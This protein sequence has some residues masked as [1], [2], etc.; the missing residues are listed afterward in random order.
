MTGSS[1]ADLHL[2]W[3]KSHAG[4]I[5]HS[6]IG[7]LMDSAATAE[8]IW[9]H[10]IPVA[11]RNAVDSACERRGREVFVATC[12]LHDIGKATP[13]FQ[14]KVPL[15]AQQV[16]D[17]GLDWGL[18]TLADAHLWHHTLA[19]AAII[20]GLTYRSGTTEIHT[21]VSSLVS[22]HHG[23]L[24][25][26]VGRPRKSHGGA[27]WVA[28]QEELAV[29]VLHR[30][31]SDLT[32]LNLPA[33]SP[34]TQ[35]SL[36]GYVTMADW[37]ASSD[38]FPGLGLRDV[39]LAEARARADR[40]WIHLGIRSG[41]D[42]SA[43]S[44]T[45]FDE[46]FGRVPAPLQD[47][48]PG[49]I[50]T[51]DGPALLIVE[52]PMGEGKTEAAL[53]ATEHLSA[54]LGF[55]GFVFAMPTQGT[56]DA[57]YSRVTKWAESV[58]REFTVSLLHG[59]AMLNQE[60]V[61]RLN[62]QHGEDL[63]DIYDEDDPF[64][65]GMSRAD[66]A[67]VPA[68]WLLGRHRSL[69][70]PGVVG[71]VDQI[72]WA[73]TRTRFVSLRHAGLAGKVVIIDEVHSFDVHMSQFVHELL[74]WCGDGGIPVLLMSATLPA[75]TRDGLVA[76]Y[77]GRD[78]DSLPQSGD[79]PRVTVAGPER[80]TTTVACASRLRPASVDVEV[81]DPADPDDL[82]PIA[83][84][85]ADEVADGG[86]ALVIL[87]T[88]ARAQGV[89]RL[90][91]DRSVD[92]EL[93]HGRLTTAE[94]ARRTHAAVAALGPNVAR[95]AQRVIVATQI[96]EQS[97]DVDADVLFSDIAPIDLLLQRMGRLHRHARSAEERPP[98]LRRPRT[99]ITGVRLGEDP[100]RWISAFD[101]V[102]GQRPE[103]KGR[104]T[105]SHAL[106]ATC[107]LLLRHPSTWTMP[108]DI[109]DLV[110]YGY[111]D[112]WRESC[113]WPEAAEQ[114][115]KDL[116][117]D[118]TRR[119]SRAAT[120]TLGGLQADLWRTRDI[121][122]L[123]ALPVDDE[124][125]VVRDGEPTLEVCLVRRSADGYF[126]LD[127]TPLG[128]TGSRATDPD[129]ARRLLGDTVRVRQD[130]RL[131]DLSAPSGFNGSHLL[132]RQPTLV[133]DGSFQATTPAGRVSYDLEVGLSIERQREG[134]PH[135]P[136]V[137]GTTLRPLTGPDDHRE[138]ATRRLY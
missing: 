106:L 97:F 12:G 62:S 85:V 107:D 53:W 2:L 88:V 129:V 27:R 84:R 45:T 119:R 79:Y 108:T 20:D 55:E 1:S 51:L 8:L 69:L 13:A 86:V 14:S 28:V 123:H 24:K 57:M 104:F 98:R 50:K 16:R 7:H 75:A 76:A 111:S 64:G 72:L 92:V 110:S 130:I 133:L 114:A 46:R 22:G 91:R 136:A 122:D 65:M 37:I 89:Y 128:P 36:L 19:G 47:L 10:F 26:R 81:L 73:A 32:V 29:L 137:A 38:E 52:A 4:G 56:T 42:P 112:A 95:P 132:A 35:L 82:Q 113:H 125:P 49:I 59:K 70:S 120:F 126:M 68:E 99:I 11:V 115:W 43:L 117:A 134:E 127:G 41:W 87:N 67:G 39:S 135:Y 61:A 9:D 58:D 138:A 31:G 63:S 80:E 121:S 25:G 33:P 6:L 30:L 74:R 77:C 96:A 100:P 54:A 48:I 90:L 21:W 17:S 101:A 60:W 116:M 118:A 103:A 93:V 109:P 66:R 78:P 83:T 124:P 18:R 71:T 15:L 5:P 3:A 102:Y 105:R 34:Q 94:R 44:Q 23:L 40:A 131:G